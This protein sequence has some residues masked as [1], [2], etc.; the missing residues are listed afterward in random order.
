[1]RIVA[2]VLFLLMAL[3]FLIAEDVREAW[4]GGEW[5]PLPTVEMEANER[6]TVKC[7]TGRM[8]IKPESDSDIRIRCHPPYDD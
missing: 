8:T 1:M 4:A 7:D 2:T 5:T 3:A 6:L